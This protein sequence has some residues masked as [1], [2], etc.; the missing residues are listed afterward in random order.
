MTDQVRPYL[1]TTYVCT[2]QLS[3]E[4]KWFSDYY[5]KLLDALNTSDLSHYFVS[6]KI[7]SLQDHERII[8]SMIQQDATK[9]LLEKVLLQLQKGN[10]SVL[11][12]M[13]LI[14][15]H[16]GVSTAKTISAEIQNK[17][18]SDK[19]AKGNNNAIICMYTYTIIMVTSDFI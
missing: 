19:G 13:L 12:K 8:K 2:D 5:D 9:L 16:Y 14:V 3:I 17:L 4:Y 10:I 11:S 7:I 6:N 18:S 1:F 15:D